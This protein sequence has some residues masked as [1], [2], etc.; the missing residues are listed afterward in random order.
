MLSRR[1]FLQFLAGIGAFGASTTAYGF[2]EPI[3]R[4]NVARYHLA[5]PRWPSDFPLKI[6]VV[7]DLHACDPWMSL[8]HIVEIVQR[9]N[10]L[11]ADVIVMLRLCRGHPPRH[12]ED[13]GGRMGAAAGSAQGAARR[14]CDPRQP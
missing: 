5:P 12:A 13:T 2:G 10:A 8:D 1:R 11:D 14:A 6:A 3:F 4:L 9:T 7:A